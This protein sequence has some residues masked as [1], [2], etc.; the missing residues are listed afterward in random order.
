MQYHDYLRLKPTIG[1]MQKT[2]M[3]DTSEVQ[4]GLRIILYLKLASSTVRHK[5]F[6]PKDDVPNSVEPAPRSKTIRHLCPGHQW[7]FF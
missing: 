7:S 1:G 3:D 6:R 2:C 5:L 4:A